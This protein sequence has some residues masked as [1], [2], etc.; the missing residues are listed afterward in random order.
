MTQQRRT[1]LFSAWQAHCKATRCICSSFALNAS[2]VVI[3]PSGFRTSSTQPLPRDATALALEMLICGQALTLKDLCGID[4][5]CYP[6][7]DAIKPS[8]PTTISNLVPTAVR[9]DLDDRRP[10]AIGDCVDVGN[11]TS[12]LSTSRGETQFSLLIIVLYFSD[13][14]KYHNMRMVYSMQF[15]R[16][17]VQKSD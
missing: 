16:P 1:N 11:L 3:E 8:I 6:D 12:L 13:L 7:S 2:A 17:G 10:E 15:A 5:P 14:S 4:G 9:L